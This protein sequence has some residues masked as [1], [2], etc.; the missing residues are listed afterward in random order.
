MSQ[1]KTGVIERE[2]TGSLHERIIAELRE[3]IVS[4]RWQ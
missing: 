4:G 2:P 3:Q 1:A